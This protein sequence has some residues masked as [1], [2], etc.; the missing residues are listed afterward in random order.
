MHAGNPIAGA[1]S[2]SFTVPTVDETS[3]NVW[4]RLHLTVRDSAGASHTVQRDI[5]PRKVTLTLATSPPGL[6]LKLD[7]QPVA[8]SSFPAVVGIVRTIGAASQTS[9]TTTYDF[10]SWS[11]G[12]AASHD[13][14]T[15]A[16]NTTTR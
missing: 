10:V 12:G 6:Q 3:A 11:D 15:P 16:A 8:T 9:G 7:G 4:Y 14:S 2:G 1:R 13:I 5:M